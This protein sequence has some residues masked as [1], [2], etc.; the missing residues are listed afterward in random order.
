MQSKGD[1]VWTDDETYYINN[2][3]YGIIVKGVGLDFDWDFFKNNIIEGK[4][5]KLKRDTISN[6]VLISKTIANRLKANVGDKLSTFFMQRNKPSERRFIV[7]GIYETGMK[8]LDDQ[9]I[10]GDIRH[11][12]KLSNWGINVTLSMLDSCYNN[13]F[14]VEAKTFGQ[15]GQYKYHWKDDKFVNSPATLLFPTKDTTIRVIG[16]I[17][18]YDMIPENQYEIALPDTAELTVRIINKKEGLTQCHC[19]LSSNETIEIRDTD[20]SLQYVFDDF[21]LDITSTSTGGSGRFYTGGFEVLINEWKDLNRLDDIIRRQKLDYKTDT[22]TI[23]EQYENIFS[24]LAMLDTNVW[25]ILILM[26]AIAVINMSSALLVMIL[27]RTNMIG[28]LKAM[29][30]RNMSIRRIF[31]NNALYL[32]GKGLLIGNIIA[33]SI[34]LIQQYFQVIKLDQTVYFVS[35][36]PIE[37]NFWYILLIN[38]GTFLICAIALILPSYLVTRISPVKAIRFN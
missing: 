26:I 24:W 21:T 8:D 29:G 13:G 17:F 6:E 19:D 33:I 27:E 28:I 7:A 34:A 18:S 2:E 38:V 30:S 35:V 1:T 31:M 9:F 10:I 20:S 11:V 32:V 36:V 25:L 23:K 22:K 16:G 15:Y 3:T 12:Q 4:A 37:L 14:I 5:L